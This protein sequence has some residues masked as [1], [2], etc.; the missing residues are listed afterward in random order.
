MLCVAFDSKLNWSDHISYFITRAYGALNAIKLIRK[1]FTAKELTSL[2]ASKF[3]SI[4]YFKL[5]ISHLPSLTNELKHLLFGASAT[6]LKAFLPYPDHS[7]SH[8]LH[9][10]TNRASSSMLCDY[11]MALLLYMT[12]NN[13]LYDE[14]IVWRKK[15]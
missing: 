5:A 7:I 13:K 12:F 1:L 8:D 3:Y 2:I 9:K 6:A 10:L 11:N 15:V 4:L 14:C